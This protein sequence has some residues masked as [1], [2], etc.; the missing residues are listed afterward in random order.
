MTNSEKD[1]TAAEYGTAVNIDSQ[2][3]A[4]YVNKNVNELFKILKGGKENERKAMR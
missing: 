2:R 3:Y 4:E 1:E